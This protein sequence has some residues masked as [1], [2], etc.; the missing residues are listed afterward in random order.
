MIS[1]IYCHD[2]WVVT[3][4]LSVDECRGHHHRTLLVPTLTYRGE[5]MLSAGSQ[6]QKNGPGCAMAAC[7]EKNRL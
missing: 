2:M 7:V 4:R 6:T 3:F 1:L 5:I